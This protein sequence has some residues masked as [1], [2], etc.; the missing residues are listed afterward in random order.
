MCVRVH[1]GMIYVSQVRRTAKTMNEKTHLVLLAALTLF[2]LLLLDLLSHKI[3]PPPPKRKRESVNMIRRAARSVV[4]DNRE[5]GQRRVFRTP[6]QFDRVVRIVIA[7]VG[8]FGG[9]LEFDCV[10]AL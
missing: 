10:G 1:V 8:A 6:V 9:Q 2:L 7:N 5:I 3:R 4:D